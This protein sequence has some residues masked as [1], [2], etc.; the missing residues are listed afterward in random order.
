M[1]LPRLEQEITGRFGWLITLALAAG[2]AFLIGQ[3]YQ[4]RHIEADSP[5]AETTPISAPIIE[6]I[7]QTLAS[8]ESE[9]GD[10]QSALGATAIGTVNINTATLAELDTLPGIGPAKAQAILD[11]RAQNGPFVRIDD[12]LN[13]SGIGPKTL[14]Q[15][16]SHITL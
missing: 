5:P 13:V 8:D 12:L 7:Q 6:Q 3:S 2:S 15:L 9:G 11:Y 16:K 14:E 10:A 1:D 4:P